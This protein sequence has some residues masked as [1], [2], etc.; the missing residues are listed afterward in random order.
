MQ[1]PLQSMAQ[2]HLDRHPEEAARVLESLP[3]DEIAAVLQKAPAGQR[4]RR[5]GLPCSRPGEC[6]PGPLP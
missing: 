5:P 6:V 4:R 3:P 1:T 2:L